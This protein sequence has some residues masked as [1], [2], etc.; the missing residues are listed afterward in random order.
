[1]RLQLLADE[2]SSLLLI[3]CAP[4]YELEKLTVGVAVDAIPTIRSNND[5]VSA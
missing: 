4:L 3:K 5:L 1:V 2:A